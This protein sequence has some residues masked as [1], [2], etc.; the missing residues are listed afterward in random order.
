VALIYNTQF[1]NL[2]AQAGGAISFYGNTLV[3]TGSSFINCSAYSIY[4]V[5]NDPN[6]DGYGGAI[7]NFAESLSITSCTFDRCS[8][9]FYGAALLNGGVNSDISDSLFVNNKA[10]YLGGVLADKSGSS[11]VSYSTFKNNTAKNGS[12]LIFFGNTVSI[13]NNKFC[14]NYASS[15]YTIDNE[16]KKNNYIVDNNTFCNNLYGAG[17]TLYAPEV[18]IGYTGTNIMYCGTKPKS[19]SDALAIGLGIGIPVAIILLVIIGIIIFMLYRRGSLRLQP[20]SQS[21]NTVPDTPRHSQQMEGNPYY[22]SQ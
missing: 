15:T 1:I 18:T 20:F 12:A 9:A 10:G 2:S 5:P 4:P 14:N 22:R 17:K 6:D 13:T 19:S 8:C 3:I 16:G 7:V 11:S 21:A